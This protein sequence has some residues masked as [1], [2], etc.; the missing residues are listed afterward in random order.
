MP[1]KNRPNR[2]MKGGRRR[3]THRRRQDAPPQR[4]DGMPEDPADAVPGVSGGGSRTTEGRILGIDFGERRV[5]IALS[6]PAGLIAHGLETITV[7]NPEESLDY[8]VSLTK[9]ER[10]FEIVLGLPLNMDGTTGEMAEKV[11]AFAGRLRGE[12]SCEVMTWDERLTSISAQRAMNEMGLEIRENKGSLDRIAATLLLQNYLD[13]R[14][15]TAG[16]SDS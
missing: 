16:K 9:A 3:V 8:I 6:D 5:G 12:V 4:V 10:V 11:E 7:K 2:T 1:R 15:G 13:S 14:R